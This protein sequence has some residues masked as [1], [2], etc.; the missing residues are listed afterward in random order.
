MRKSATAALSAPLQLPDVLLL[1]TTVAGDGLLRCFTSAST[2][3]CR[4]LTDLFA[5]DPECAAK[6]PD[7]KL[8]GGL[9]RSMAFAGAGIDDEL[10]LKKLQATAVFI[11]LLC[12][13]SLASLQ[14]GR[15]G[16]G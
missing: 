7:K 4:S 2:L 6:A 9:A 3:V 14:A 13:A 8:V 11:M 16:R 15:A 5:T 12:W 1:R 10:E